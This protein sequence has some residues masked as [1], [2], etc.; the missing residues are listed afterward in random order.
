L[1]EFNER[2]VNSISD[3]LLLIDPNDYT[4][5]SANEAALKQLKLRKED[6]IGKACYEIT[7]HRST[8]CKPPHHICPIQEMLKTGK[9]VTLKHIH[10]DKENNEICIEVSAHPVKNQ[11]GNIVQVVHLAKD[12]TER[13]LAEEKLIEAHARLEHLISLSPIVIYTSVFKGKW[14]NTFVSENVKNVLGYEPREFLEN[15][16]FWVERV[17]PDDITRL[18]SKSPHLPEEGR[19]AHEYRFLHKDG[20]YRWMF[21]EL[22]IEH[23]PEGKPLRCVGYWMDITERKQM[24]EKLKESEERLRQLIEYAPDSIFLYDSMGRFIDGNRQAE[25]MTGYKKEELIGKNFLTVG[26]LPMEY[27]QKSV[28]VLAKSRAGQRTGPLEL[29]LIRKDSSTVTVET[30]TFPVK[31]EG[32]VE[33]IGIARD[34]TERKALEKKLQEYAEHLEEMVEE[35]TR[36]LKESEAK[37]KDLFKTIPDSVAIIDLNANLLEFNE[38]TLELFGYSREQIIGKN[39]FDFIAEEDREKAVQG[40]KQTL[41]E[42]SVRIQ[43]MV[44]RKDGRKIPV[45]LNSSVLKDP[46]GNLVGFVGVLRD[47]TERKRME[48]QLLKSERMAAIGQLATMVG[49][50]LRNPLTSLQNACYYLK[51]KLESSKDKKIKKMFEVMD[52]E[53]NHANNI[54]KD[55]LDFARVKKPELKKVDLISSIQEALTQLK[56]PENVKLTTKFSEV[57]TI[58]ADPDQ[59][60]RIFQNIALNGIQ[61]M[62]NS[63]KLT[64]STRKNGSFIEVAFTDTGVGIPEENMDK[65]FTPLFTTKAQGVG[66][67]LPICKNL[68]E[69]HNGRIEV[70]SK[71]GE[72]STFTVKLPIH[73]NQGGEKQV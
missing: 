4:I 23:D 21:N 64:V 10:F 51:M 22:K 3:A 39:V 53:I 57:P 24:E 41:E 20:T 19:H 44:S 5:I 45:E 40:M 47:I 52:K 61:A 15:P 29:E 38:T 36:E 56:F 66:L 13:K 1:K 26:L 55:L 59:L 30:S 43:L 7:H 46:T 67:G 2:I 60:R 42:G 33:I 27:L 71:V 18:H 32:K 31:R 69:G 9:V 58:E 12:I 17:H 14:V 37:L 54:V 72:G 6:I 16:N 25:E 35:R 28:E 63:G 48:E 65:I 49:H 8:P 73:Q 50:D 62:P 11:K 34:I 68:V 70:K